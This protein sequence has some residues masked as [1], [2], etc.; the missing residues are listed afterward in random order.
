M[1]LFDHNGPGTAGTTTTDLIIARLPRDRAMILTTQDR[2]TWL[3]WRSRPLPA[4]EADRVAELMSASLPNLIVH[5]HDVTG[6]DDL[7]PA[8][9]RPDGARIL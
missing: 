4:A 5:R 1:S 9:L 6:P 7:I 3:R 2:R 8:R